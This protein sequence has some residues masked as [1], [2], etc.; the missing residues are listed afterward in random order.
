MKT[1]FLKTCAAILLGVVVAGHD[2]ARA[3]ARE[4]G[5]TAGVVITNRAEVTYRDDE[6]FDY[7]S[8]SQTVTVTIQAVA[9]FIFTPDETVPSTT[10]G[11]Q[12]HL[13]RVFRICNTGNVA[14]TY[15]I[16]S[17][18][19][20][21]PASLANL[22]F[23]TDATGSFTSADHA[24][25][26][27]GSASPQVAPGACIG[28]LAMVDTNDATAN[29][30]LIFRLSAR[31]NTNPRAVD[32][33]TIINE[34]GL[35]A[36]LTSPTDANLPPVKSVN[37]SSQAVVSPGTPFTYTI[38]FRN[39]GDVT[40]R[41]VVVSDDLLTQLE[42]VPG[43]LHLDNRSLTDLQDTDEGNVQGQ[44]LLVQLA[45]VAPGQ[46]V[47][48]SFQAR[49]N[50]S[51]TAGVGLPNVGNITGQNVA[52]TQSTKAIVV[53]NPFGTVFA[54]RGGSAALIAQANVE[55]LV[56]QNGNKLNIPSGDGFAPN[57]Q[58]ENPFATDGVGHFSFVLPTEQRG[59]ET[60]PAHYFVKVSA[61]GYSTRMLE[62]AVR[63]NQELFRLTVHSL[64]GQPL[65]KAG[66]FDLVTEDVSMENMAALVLN[67]PMFEQHGLTLLKSVDRP[68]AEIGDAV[69]YR[70]EI[71]NPTAASVFDVVVHDRLPA[72]FHYATGTARLTVGS[73]IESAV[74][75]EIAGNELVFH[76]GEIG[77]GATARLLYRARIGANAHEGEQENV[78]VANGRF[79]NGDPTQTAPARASVIV[80]RGAFSTRQIILGRVF[81]D[82]NRNE[83]FDDGDMPL[84]GVRLFLNSGQSVVTDSQ[85]LYNFPSLGDGAQV[86]SL[87]PM[88][89][90]KRYALTDN[91]S[92]AG[93]SWT[94]LLRTPL[95][96]GALLRQNFALAPVDQTDY[97]A[98]AN[99]AS[100]TRASAETISPASSEVGPSRISWPKQA[101]VSRYRLQL[102]SDES[103]NDIIFDDSVS[104]NEYSAT[105][106]APGRYFWRVAAA[107]DKTAQFTTSVAFEVK[108]STTQELVTS[109]TLEP[110]A[111]GEVTVLSPAANTV[112]MSPALQLEA[113]VA[114]NWKVSLEING[115]AV[116]EKN[117]GT[118]RQDHKNNV[119]TFTYV[120]VEL[121]PGPNTLRVSAIS[122]QGT[123]GHSRE[124]VVQGRGPARR[125]AIT[126]EKNEIQTGGHDSTLIRVRAFD[127]WDNPAADDQ[128]AVETSIGKLVRISQKDG[129]RAG[130][131]K[132]AEVSSVSSAQSAKPSFLSSRSAKNDEDVKN[133]L[134]IVSLTGGEAVLQLSAPGAP[135][136]ARL[137]AQ[138]G[139]VEAEAKVRITPESRPTILVGLAEMTFG[140][141]LPEVNL[142]GEE[143][144]YRNRLSFFYSGRVGD[145]NLLT[146]SYDSQR[147]IN[148]TAGRDRLFNLDPLD[149]V[150]P[151][152]GDSS[153]RFEAAQSNSKLYARLD[154]N[155]SYAMFGDFDADMEDVSLAGYSRKL[156]GIKLHLENSRGDFVTV[157]GARPDTAFARDV[158]PAGGVGLLNLS[159]GEIL[160]G[161]EVVVLEVR[162]RRNP[163][164]ILS[165]ETL[166]RSV[167]YNLNPVTGE[168]FFLRYI[169]TF[170]FNFNLAQ[171]VVTYEHRA[172]SLST[173]VYTARARKNFTGVGLQL[174]LAGMMQRQT[175]A[176]SFVVAG[177]DGEKKLPNKGTMRF[178][179]ARS[180]GEIMGSGNFFNTADT[181]HNGNA[182]LLE[183]NQ[184]LGIYQGVVRARYSSA[185]AG[186]LNPFG[187][188]VTAGSQRGEVSLELKPRTS[189]LFRFALMDERNHTVTVNNSRLTFSA[190]W[191]Q[192]VNERVRFHLGYDHRSLSDDVSNRGV[193]SDLVTASAE[194]KLTDKLQVALK[195]EQNLGE[196]D[197][198]YPNQTTLAATYKVN[199]WAKVF[200]TQRIAAAVISPIGDFSGAG[201]S[202]T[203]SRSETALGVETRV[204][205]YSSMV[206]RYQLENGIN[207]TDSFAVIGLQNRL[208]IT[209]QLSLELGFERGFHIAGNGASFNSATVGF[210]WQPT[211]DFRSSARYQFRDRAG[212]GQLIALGAAGRIRE[213]IT[214]LS[215]FQWARTGFE[216]RHGSS[217]DAMG[218]LAF[219]PLTSDRAGLLFSYTH[220]SLVQDGSATSSIQTRDRLDSLATDGYFQATD[221]LELYGRV[222]LR[223]S[224]NGQANL[225]Y[226]STLTYLTQG[227]AQYRLTR[228]LD[229]AGEMRLLMQPSS[230]TS[231]SSFGSELGLW[232]LPDLRL[233]A[234]YNFAL[235]GEPGNVPGIATKRG[236]YFTITSKLS[237]LFNLFGTAHND[238]VGSAESPTDTGGKP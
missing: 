213:G 228:R 206:G 194:V 202:S 102:S 175:D 25:Q 210:G 22:Y 199:Q 187:A 180:Q 62:V 231:H 51:V 41:S 227:R 196:A 13:T 168:L 111:P 57:L 18:D 128:V 130:E 125:L 114:L 69:A 33:G 234:G 107:Q 195:R 121:R 74:E 12:E 15:T 139:Q 155:R 226:V 163:E 20:S 26:V 10:V 9:S 230:G 45:Q 86:I 38:A 8:A 214:A 144:H 5:E 158:F 171:L 167:D 212:S 55:I 79:L 71:N 165:R 235:S 21:S 220:R 219:R 44:R 2:G 101:G 95:G 104:G 232:A 223:L 118:I 138:M 98:A 162:D 99:H 68:R 43:S 127:E 97:V 73:A 181:A 48:I 59:T 218:A 47:S 87:D 110:V 147:P 32:E 209:K 40:A 91:G 88:T 221:K 105:E 113:R 124:L 61:R 93:R 42:Y 156:T 154:R 146:L 123:V 174:G 169:S 50:G 126:A 37:G 236:F 76:I 145:R 192:I 135:G 142:R 182:Y 67:I 166:V 122:P 116:S 132:N 143:G 217:L 16:I 152:F 183:L 149:R 164:I 188:T 120:G 205:K 80:G 216:G 237:N 191:E 106:L 170:D 176:G 129:I 193:Q 103:F 233:G 28:I 117:V 137:R 100:P 23:D 203:G 211:K 215:R 186:F 70:V 159:S 172:N 119:T 96:G 83:Q 27:N 197:P 198:T 148:R 115:K 90:A 29:S 184:P 66:A 207:G 153:T 133:D 39:S 36:R 63:P 81:V 229:W 157:T 82:A 136:E 161:S 140:Q 72:S 60:S 85:G 201:F 49:L 1:S 24:T 35:G 109:E 108:S 78:A 52:P 200:L 11:S 208:P 190:A 134:V 151:L 189:T 131:D 75:P 31:S 4:V 7:K 65:A 92:L 112:V 224:A 64:D 17:A 225:P 56:D 160:P 89:L 178:A 185:S 58:N 19:M 204:G 46:I 179:F 177:F 34:V 77:P 84:P 6:G 30:R 150:Y 141:S 14:D 238:F 53:V 222:A 173:A 54:G 3:F 94:R